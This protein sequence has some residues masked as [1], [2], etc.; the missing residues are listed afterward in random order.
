VLRR[1]VFVCIVSLAVSLVSCS[2]PPVA[3]PSSTSREVPI[4]DLLTTEPNALQPD[5][6]TAIHPDVSFTT[7]RGVF[8]VAPNPVLVATIDKPEDAITAGIVQR[9]TLNQT[10]ARP[11]VVSAETRA[12]GTARRRFGDYALQVTLLDAEGNGV[13]GNQTFFDPIE[14][15][16]Q[17]AELQFVP[18]TPVATVEV[19]L[20]ALSKSGSVEFRAPKVVQLPADTTATTLDG[21]AL[22]MDAELTE[23]W[24][25]VDA[26]N[27]R[28]FFPA[29]QAEELGLTITPRAITDGD[30]TQLTATI[31]D[32]TGHDRAL[33]LIYIQPVAQGEWDWLADPRRSERA[34]EGR[35]YGYVTGVQAGRGRL[36]LWPFAAIASDTE[37]RAIALDLDAPAVYRTGYSSGTGALYI[38]FDIALTPERPA[39]DLSACTFTFDPEWGFRSAMKT[40]YE[41]FPDAFADRAG[42]HG[43]WIPFGYIPGIEGWEDFGFRFNEGFADVNWSDEHEVLSF[44]YCEPMTYWMWMP[45]ELPRTRES[46]LGYVEQL[47]DDGH[48]E[49]Q[50]YLTSVYHDPHGRPVATAMVAPWCDGALWSMNTAP[51]VVGEVTDFNRMW[52]E[53]SLTMS[54][55]GEG[56]IGGDGMY[57]DSIEGFLID[58][59]NFRR[60]HFAAMD[61]PL[62]FDSLSGKPAIFTPLVAFEFTRAVS[63]DLHERDALAMAN[64]TPARVPWLAPL[65]DVMGSELCWITKDQWTPSGEQ[66]LIFV[67][68]MCGDKPYCIVQNADFT[69][70]T[71]EHTELY[72]KRCA[73]YGMYPGFFSPNAMSDTYFGNPDYYNRDRDLFRKYIPLCRRAGEAGWEP[74]TYATS[75]IDTIHAERFGKDCLTVFNDGTDV[76]TVTLTLTGPLAD[77]TAATDLV[78]GDAL[79]IDNATL[80]LTL[81]PGDVA[82]LE[83]EL[84]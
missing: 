78:S 83:L 55:G 13:G 51:G 70:W 68:A 32:T 14:T 33:T 84:P 71:R 34:D 19:R 27:P 62:T 38:A 77:A 48:G 49:A 74:V 29:D 64:T 23:G 47:A 58:E 41:L 7:E 69:K 36:G 75:N 52:T 15:E 18:S 5:A 17:H 21:R 81:E 79:P 80:T 25:I 60:D 53:A 43:I 26:H 6:W 57:I 8:R 9:A 65:L 11:I 40:F 22:S 24:W 3:D 44:N 46:I 2:R 56:Q 82:T 72:M 54:A 42:K 4:I 20:V 28:A 37:G 10:I 16:W 50:A 39:A 1:C 67:R 73:A 61:T 35:E 31:T 66:W 63:S 12:T 30:N 76:Q 59:L 45:S